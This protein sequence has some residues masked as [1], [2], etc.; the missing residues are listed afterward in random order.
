MS[1]INLRVDNFQNL[2]FQSSGI[3]TDLCDL[4]KITDSGSA[5][6]SVNSYYLIYLSR[7]VKPTKGWY[8][9]IVSPP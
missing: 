5:T 2:T 4:L 6:Q 8:L 9:A 3:F 7:R 1:I